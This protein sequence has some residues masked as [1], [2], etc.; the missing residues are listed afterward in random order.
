MKQAIKYKIK[1]SRQIADNLDKLEKLREYHRKYARMRT[2]LRNLNG[3]PDPR[4]KTG[5][6]VGRPYKIKVRNMDTEDGKEEKNFN[7]D[8]INL[9]KGKGK[10]KRY[11]WD[12]T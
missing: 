9:K 4:N 10:I 8:D 5:R 11:D 1:E 7:E 6:R 12:R 3:I 2:F